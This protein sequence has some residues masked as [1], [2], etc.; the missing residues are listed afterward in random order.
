MRTRTGAGGGR[1]STQACGGLPGC[2]GARKFSMRRGRYTRPPVL[3]TVTHISPSDARA[4]SSELWQCVQDTWTE[5]RS[6]EDRELGAR[7]RTEGEH[8]IAIATVIAHSSSMNDGWNEPRSSLRPG[9]QWQC[10][11]RRTCAASD[12]TAAPGPKFRLALQL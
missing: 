11:H 12:S 10:K 9:S 4:P 8:A 6:Q 3:V 5:L 7:A 2:S 1:Y